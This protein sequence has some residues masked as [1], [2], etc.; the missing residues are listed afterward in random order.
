V[1]TKTADEILA[2]IA[3]LALR[4]LGTHAFSDQPASRHGAQRST[5]EG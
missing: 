2:S 3:C 5:E 4:A 1:S